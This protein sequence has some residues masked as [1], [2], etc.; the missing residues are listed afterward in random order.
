MLEFHETIRRTEERHFLAFMPHQDGLQ[1]I[2][3]ALVL[4][5]SS[6]LILRL[7]FACYSL[8]LRLFFACYSLVL[9]LLFA[10]YSLVLRLFLAYSSLILRLF[11][12]CS[13]LILRLF[14]AHSSRILRFFSLFFAS[15]LP[16]LPFFYSSFLII[17]N[18]TKDLRT[19][20]SHSW[21]GTRMRQL[22]ERWQCKARIKKRR[23]EEGG[24]ANSKY[25]GQ[26][27]G[28]AISML[29]KLADTKSGFDKNTTLLSYMVKFLYKVRPTLLGMG[30][31]P[32]LQE[33]GSLA[34]SLLLLVLVFVRLLFVV[35]SSFV[36]LLFVVCSSFVRNYA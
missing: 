13:S 9:R 8:I 34:V 27:D 16:S 1:S 31:E 12:A 2:E 28:F 15:S 26:A 19:I 36:R 7:F 23:G 33:A 6:S 17:Q 22:F 24:I 29:P 35:C 11:F 30:I 21:I 25:R 20:E 4:V 14:F 5:P 18:L 10:C 3:G 32:K